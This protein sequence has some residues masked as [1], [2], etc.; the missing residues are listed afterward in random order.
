M[1]SFVGEIALGIVVTRLNGLEKRASMGEE[2]YKAMFRRY[3][4]YL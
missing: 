2:G 1:V 3:V 4:G